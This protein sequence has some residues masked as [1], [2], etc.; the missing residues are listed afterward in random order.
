MY[1]HIITYEKMLLWRVSL[2]GELTLRDAQLDAMR[3]ALEGTELETLQGRL[4]EHGRC[5]CCSPNPD[6]HPHWTGRNL[7]QLH[8]EYLAMQMAHLAHTSATG[9]NTQTATSLR[10][11]LGHVSQMAHALDTTAQGHITVLQ[12]EQRAQ[13]V[14]G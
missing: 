9:A 1:E 11:E 13:R 7:E 10:E 6:A 2:K 5:D 14:C 3:A 8:M 12:V 4:S